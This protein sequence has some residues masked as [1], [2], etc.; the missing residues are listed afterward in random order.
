MDPEALAALLA[1][2]ALAP[3]PGVTPNFDSPQNQNVLAY[4]VTSV[5]S[6]LL[7]LCVA[8]RLYSRGYL[9]KGFGVE[10]ALMMLGFGAYWGTAY[11]GFELVLTPGYYVHTWDLRLGDVIRPAYLILIYGCCYSAVLPLIKTAILLDWCR[12]FVP[13]ERSDNLF[14][15]GCVLLGIIQCVWG[16]A[17]IVLLNMQCV[18]YNAIWVFYVP[19]RCYSLPNV[20]LASASV[21][22][23]TDITMVLLPQRIIWK[24]Q[25][26]WKKRAGVSLIFGIGIAGSI[27]ACLRLSKTITF[28][29]EADTMYFIGPL[30]FWA[31]AE[32]TCGF[33]IFSVPSMPRILKAA[34]RGT[35]AVRSAYRPQQPTS[36]DYSRGRRRRAGTA[37]AVRD[38]R[39]FSGDERAAA[40]R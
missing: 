14:W 30:L 38:G 31:C 11:A 19:S 29:H 13:G 2:P 36:S 3:P 15:W 39:L 35:A 6:C 18:P 26:S 22:V 32:M 5:L 33:L 9:E 4:A 10:D 17:C 37:A 28:A 21:Q 24:L 8:I 16:V 40:R 25:M 27:S 12:I 23:F 20:M 7:T 34:F 1:S